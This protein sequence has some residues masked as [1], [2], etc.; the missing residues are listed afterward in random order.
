MEISNDQKHHTYRTRPEPGQLVEA[1][2]GQG[3]VKAHDAGKRRPAVAGGVFGLQF[4]EFH[5]TPP[6]AACASDIRPTDPYRP[7]SRWIRAK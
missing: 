2:R 1:V 4:H 5:Q 3:F 6:E 7:V